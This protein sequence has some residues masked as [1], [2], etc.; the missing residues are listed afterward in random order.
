VLPARLLR[1]RV[2]SICHH[3][4]LTATVLSFSTTRS[5]CTVKIQFRSVRL[6]RRNA[7]PF[8][9]AGTLN[10][11]LNSPMYRSRRKALAPSAVVIPASRS[12]CGKRP[13]QVPKLRS[14]LPSPGANSRD[15]LHSQLL[16]R[17]P[18]LRQ[19]MFIHLFPSFTVTKK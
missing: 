13:C 12:S 3:R 10:L 7:V 15:H 17:P 2:L 18:N 11:L 5:V 19:A 9:A 1:N 8:S 4:S 14:D 16:H 6:V